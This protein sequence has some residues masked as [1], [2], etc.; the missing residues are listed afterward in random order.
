M[1]EDTLALYY[2]DGSQWVKEPSSVVDTAANTVTAHARPLLSLGGAGRDRRSLA[3]PKNERSGPEKGRR[4]AKP[5][6]GLWGRESGPAG[7]LTCAFS[8]QRS[9]SLRSLRAAADAPIV[10]R[11]QVHKNAKALSLVVCLHIDRRN[12]LL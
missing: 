12:L 8:R 1:V 11:L 5:D 9:A 6:S 2:W 4:A 10:S 7:L 3:G